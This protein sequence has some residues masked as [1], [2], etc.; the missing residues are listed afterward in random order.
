MSFIEYIKKELNIA[1]LIVLLGFAGNVL[2]YVYKAAY[3]F[4]FQI[5]TSM[6]SFSFYEVV[7]FSVTPIVLGMLYVYSLWITKAPENELAKLKAKYHLKRRIKPVNK[8]IVVLGCLLI[9]MVQWYITK[10]LYVILMA[11]LEG[12]AILFLIFFLIKNNFKAQ[13][14]SKEIKQSKREQRKLERERTAYWTEKE[15]VMKQ[16]RMSAADIEMAAKEETAA[17]EEDLGQFKDKLKQKAE[18]LKITFA[19]IIAV[20]IL[21]STAILGK[22]SGQLKKEYPIIVYQG[23]EYIS[24]AEYNDHFICM[25]NDG[26]DEIDPQYQLI[27]FADAEKIYTKRTG[28]LKVK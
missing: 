1:A 19:I 8:F 12:V 5:P 16:R 9:A 13:G 20:V 18:P 21:W 24:V 23:T 10:N 26:T 7:L 14:E 6:I 15:K 11:V 3:F 28:S 25:A 22:Q 2:A 17:A 4:Y 27:A